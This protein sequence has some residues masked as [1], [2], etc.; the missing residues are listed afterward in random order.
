[1]KGMDG[2]AALRHIRE[3]DKNAKIIM[4]TALDDQDKMREADKL[5]AVDYITKPLALDHLE[6]TVG[7]NLKV[8][9]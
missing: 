4:V 8:S 3:F 5:G 6:E 9:L 1:M 7:K 2:I